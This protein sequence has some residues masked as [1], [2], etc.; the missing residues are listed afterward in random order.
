MKERYFYKSLKLSFS[1]LLLISF[2]VH[3]AWDLENL[4]KLKEDL[5]KVEKW[6]EDNCTEQD[7]HSNQGGQYC[8]QGRTKTQ[9][10]IMLHGGP[11][12]VADGNGMWKSRGEKIVGEFKDNAPTGL[13]MYLYQSGSLYY[14]ELVRAKRHGNGVM[15]LSD[16]TV[17]KGEFKNNKFQQVFTQAELDKRKA[18]WPVT[19]ECNS[20]TFNVTGIYIGM[21]LP[22]NKV[23]TQSIDSFKSLLNAGIQEKPDFDI[24]EGPYVDDI[25]VV[26]RA[27][28]YGK[29]VKNKKE[30][31][32]RL[33]L[34][35]ETLRLTEATKGQWS[36]QYVN[37]DVLDP[38]DFSYQDLNDYLEGKWKEFK[39]AR[40]KKLK[41]RAF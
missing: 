9:T 39:N 26:W 41:K 1:L 30:G 12:F 13:G 27:N 19:I 34:S 7:W 36:G 8:G 17:Q 21:D 31:G 20:K 18:P 23:Y 5:A 32:R 35:R 25:K 3:S 6:L 10:E 2:N 4:D 15:Y 11:E 28:V 33:T 14:G 24:Y 22:N 16:G 40:E 37:C 29:P 38:K